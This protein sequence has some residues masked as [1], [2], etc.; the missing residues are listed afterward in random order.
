MISKRRCKPRTEPD[1]DEPFLGNDADADAMT[2]LLA[3]QKR[4]MD[5]YPHWAAQPD[6]PLGEI[7]SPED[8]EAMAQIF[9]ACDYLSDRA[10]Y[11]EH[12]DQRRGYL[13][14]E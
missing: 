4:I 14:I 2:I 12:A 1:D 7:A 11:A 13:V 6:K 8:I 10:D 5:K 3:A 9:H